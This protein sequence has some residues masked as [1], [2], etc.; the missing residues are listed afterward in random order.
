MNPEL[1]AT[2]LKGVGE[3]ICVFCQREGG[4]LNSG[5]ACP[6]FISGPRLSGVPGAVSR[7]SVVLLGSQPAALCLP[8]CQE[9]PLLTLK[10]ILLTAALAGLCFPESPC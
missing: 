8:K 2:I 5:F 10:I 9:A 1:S 3:G 6:S 7:R 4:S